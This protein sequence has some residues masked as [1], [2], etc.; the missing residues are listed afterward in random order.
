LA[1]AA[2]LSIG[3]AGALAALPAAAQIERRSDRVVYS[4]HA[5]VVDQLDELELALYLREATLLLQRSQGPVDAACCTGLEAVELEVFGAPGDGLDAIDSE[6]EW[7]QLGNRKAIVQSIRWCGNVGSNILGC[8]E[9]PGERLAVALDADPED[10]ALVLAHER[11]HNAGLSHRTND[12]CALM[13]PTVNP[14][15]GCV[16]SAECNAF[17]VLGYRHPPDGSCDCLGPLVG[18][19]VRSDGS[20]CAEDGVAGACR[21]SGV[22]QASLLNETCAAAAA[23]PVEGTLL[24]E[25]YAG[26][27]DDGPTCSV[28]LSDLWYRYRAP[29]SGRLQLD[30]CNSA[31][32]ALVELRGDCAGGDAGASLACSASCDLEACRYGGAC[33][34]AIVLAGSE[35]R[36]R[37]GRTAG[38][39]GPF[40]LRADCAADLELDADQD[41][42][43]GAQELALGSDPLD[44]DTD[45]DGVPDGADNCLLAPNPDQRD[46]GGAAGPGDPGLSPDGRGDACQCGDLDGDGAAGA[47]DVLAFRQHL[48]DPAAFPI[49]T[50]KCRVWR[51]SPACDPAQLAVLWRAVLGAAPGVSPVCAAAT[52]A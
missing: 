9:T 18:D 11:G 10:L 43:A 32:A 28:A 31:F 21:A 38:A 46:A 36:L 25:W 13:R 50:S 3:L 12:S 26:T 40:L 2:W 45:R 16:N 41:G 4:V 47:G 42:L 27:L 48:A 14:S 17:R 30:L 5:D 24:S 8:A 34:G 49:D 51:A 6:Q 1:R 52:G 39:G 15:H 44:A 33:A 37:V 20:P 29:C 19:P 22:C 7:L 35:L 23:L